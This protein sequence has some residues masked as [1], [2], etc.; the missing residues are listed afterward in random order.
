MDIVKYGHVR[1]AIDGGSFSFIWFA[2]IFENLFRWI[3]DI[4]SGVYISLLI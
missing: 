4:F 2:A 3:R 1:L